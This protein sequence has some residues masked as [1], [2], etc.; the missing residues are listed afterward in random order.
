MMLW[1][2]TTLM[3]YTDWFQYQYVGCIWHALWIVFCFSLEEEE[4]KT[5]IQCIQFS[6]GGVKWAFYC[7]RHFFFFGKKSNHQVS[8][9]ECRKCCKKQQRQKKIE[10]FHE[11][12]FHIFV[13]F[14]I[15]QEMKEE[16]KKTNEW[17]NC[18][19][20]STRCKFISKSKWQKANWK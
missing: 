3:M 15:H 16:K 4:K 2:M 9:T 17:T 14:K 1:T 7:F 18:T 13:S 12:E 5:R 8:L 11:N 6:I 20:I 10:H 19:P